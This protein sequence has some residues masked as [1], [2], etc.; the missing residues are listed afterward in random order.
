MSTSTPAVIRTELRGVPHLGVV[1]G[2]LEVVS[3]WRM[4][5]KAGTVGS[6]WT[7][8]SHPDGVDGA[9]RHVGICRDEATARG[10]LESLAAAYRS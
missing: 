10:A 9:T 2:D 5:G 7:V 8:V 4:G 3:A 6:V 1:V